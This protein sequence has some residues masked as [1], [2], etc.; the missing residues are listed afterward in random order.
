[1]RAILTSGKLKS[2]GQ[3]FYSEAKRQAY[4]LSVA[5]EGDTKLLEIQS[6]YPR[7]SRVATIPSPSSSTISPSCV[8]VAKTSVASMPL[9]ANGCVF[10]TA[11]SLA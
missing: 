10:L 4:I 8:S 7:T 1:M 3:A 9:L 2:G 11:G 6:I 5:D